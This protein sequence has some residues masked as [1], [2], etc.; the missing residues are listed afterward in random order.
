MSA[1]LRFITVAFSLIVCAHNPP[2]YAAEACA[3]WA[4]KAVSVQGSVDVQ[5]AG[6]SAWQ[7][8]SLGASICP[9]DS[10]RVGEQSRAGLM[11]PNETVV[12][13]DQNTFITL[14]AV[15]EEAPSL[16]DLLR[17]AV[18]FI[19]RVPRTLKIKTPYVNA[20]I[21]GTEFLLQVRESDT[22]LVV[23]E[24]RV[25][26]ENQSGRLLLASGQAAV[27]A[28]GKPPVLRLDIDLEDA[29]RWTLYYPAVLYRPASPAAQN[30]PRAQGLLG[31]GRVEEAAVI[32]NRVLQAEPGNSDALALNSIIA[33]AQNRVD[34]SLEL[35]DKAVRSDPKS[36]SAYIARS[37]ALQA[38]FD[39]KGARAAIERASQYHPDHALA[40]ARLAELWQSLGYL[41]K[42]V[43]AA[44]KAAAL[45]ADLA[46]TQTV[47]GFAYLTQ[48]RI[49]HARAAFERA[50]DLDQAAPLA[51]LGLGLAMIR[52]GRLK[53]GRRNLEI[54]A[55][56]D[57]NNSLVRS[58]LGKAYF[59]E[60][61]E[62][63]AAN[64]FQLAKV[65]DPRDP[66]PWFY[67]AILKQT[68]NR[69][70][71]AL[72]DLHQAIKLNDNRAVY[73][74][75]LLLDQDLAARSASLARI[76]RDLGFEQ[77]AL[78]EGWKSVNTASANYS[79]HR[80]LADAYAGRP[81]QEVARVSELLQSQ[82]LQPLNLTPLQP[83]L[84]ESNLLLLQAQGPAAPSFN[85]F[86]PLFVSNGLALQAAGVAGNKDSWGNELVQSG[87]WNKISYSLGQLH[88]ETDGFRDNNNQET[89]L[90][91]V[92]LQTS[93]SPTLSLQAEYRHS[94]TDHGDLA[95]NWD[96][97]AFNPTFER[98]LR[99]DTYRV[100]ARLA[101]RPDSDI[102]ASFIYQDEKEKQELTLFDTQ[103]DSDGYIAEVQHLFSGQHLGTT[104]GIGYYDTDS[105]VQVTSASFSSS[106]NFNTQHKNAYLYSYID[107]PRHF[108]WTLGGSFD[109]LDHG[110]LGDFNQFNPKLGL[111]W[112]I[113]PATLL[114]AAALRVLK[115]S[116]LTDQTIEPT[117]V[118]G[119]NQFFDDR[120]GTDA[121]RY[122]IAL[123][124]TFSQQLYAG[125]EF[126]RR[127]LDVPIVA[128][129]TI[130]EDWQEDLF[131]AYLNWTPHPR[132]AASVAYEFEDFD[133][134]AT[135]TSIPHTKT[136]LLP[137]D[138]RYFH[139]S[140]FFAGVTTS[141]VKQDVDFSSNEKD[142]ARFTLV[143]VALGYRFPK[144]YG[145]LSLGVRN[146]FDK[147]FNFQGLGFRTLAEENPRF[148]PERTVAARL[149]LSF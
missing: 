56:L 123:D 93:I 66:T 67:D 17:G 118:A 135:N 1:R 5:R 124:Q 92:F 129:G 48:I 117:Q 36:A 96:L 20:A 18:H 86:N 142:D 145:I 70:V 97:D 43:E 6:G 73:R 42:S 55:V 53:A 104:V 137:V 30:L 143:D 24:G 113:S 62:Q 79:A 140:G 52:D 98:D 29:V 126:S 88:F 100:G 23:Y 51:R 125:I 69:P 131:Q 47:L 101:P 61:R 110:S 25:T 8:T 127:D 14:S 11:L 82:L 149:T 141:H 46:L 122:G 49:G 109:S 35:A 136:R 31:V 4:A 81:R 116:L 128:S 132:F 119:F 45:D 130:T 112:E 15:E 103:F 39:L 64:S 72:Y 2:T 80:F 38:R 83:Q 102:I 41:K 144:R 121:W 60:R 91:N 94:T 40:W 75:K 90:Y 147:N 13:L 120:N 68:T 146:L 59:D 50:I 89:N 58:Y 107:G 85:E 84:A 77:L 28:P 19:S 115:R 26:A 27:G 21:E 108:T 63:L 134:D 105:D 87:I 37:Y 12:R 32:I 111:M 9:G 138:L 95:L 114:R 74:S 33:L 106:T 78:T 34:M 54:A 10:I 7:A 57:P 99:T 44:Q 133:A 22:L 76:Y 3:P 139:P 65:L 16:L 148:L 71:D